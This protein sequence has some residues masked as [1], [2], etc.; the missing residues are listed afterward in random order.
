MA[1]TDWPLAERPRE[2][3]LARGPRALSDAEL[4]AIFLRTGIPGS[5]A[6]E[7]ARELLTGFGGLG[8]VWRQHVVAE[9]VLGAVQVD[10]LD[11]R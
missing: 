6:V 5:T 7:L 1:I 11:G 9:L 3:L 2:K 4:V 8:V 10:H